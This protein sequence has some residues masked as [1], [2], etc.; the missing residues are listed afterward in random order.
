MLKTSIKYAPVCGLFMILIYHLS[1]RFGVNPQIDLSHLLFDLI[2]LGLFIFFTAKDFKTYRND[3][4]FHFWQGMTIGFQVYMIATVIFCLSQ[5]IY[6]TIDAEAVINY[7]EEATNFL[8]ERS[9]LFIEKFGDE[10]YAL[11]LE[12]IEKV[13]KWD[14]IL[15][16]SGKKLLAGFFITPVISIILRKQP[17]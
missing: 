8:K 17:N 1:F 2:L 13:G 10:G 9:G 16:S 15:G 6:F 12:E 5:I 3:G 14:L 7:R 11:Q 4:V